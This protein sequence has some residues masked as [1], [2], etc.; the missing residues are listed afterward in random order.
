MRY[1]IGFWCSRCECGVAP[2]AVVTQLQQFKQRCMVQQLIR[3]M[4]V[5]VIIKATPNSE[6]G[7]M[8]SE[9]LLS[10]MGNFNEKMSKQW[11]LKRQSAL[12]THSRCSASSDFHCIH[13]IVLAL[14]AL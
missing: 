4:R 6:A 1:Y 9:Q 5:M 8:P 13:C 12:I 11:L 2:A 10:D 14:I 7:I 3:A